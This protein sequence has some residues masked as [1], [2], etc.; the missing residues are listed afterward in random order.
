MFFKQTKKQQERDLKYYVLEGVFWAITHYIGIVFLVPYLIRFNASTMEI[1]LINT[2]PLFLSSFSVLFSY[3][4]LK[5]FESQKHFIVFFLTLQA[6]FWIPLAFVGYFFKDHFAVWIIIILYCITIFAEQFTMG[7]YR[8]WIGK[9]FDVSKIVQLNAKKQIILN[10]VSIVPLF[11]AGFILDALQ[12]NSIFGFTLIFIIAGVFK[13]GTVMMLKKMSQTE[14][15]E[16]IIKES[17]KKAKSPFVIFKEVVVKNKQFVYFLLI[18]TL[19]YFGMYVASPFYRYYFLEILHFNYKQYVLLEIAT[20]LSLILSYYYWGKICDKYGSTKVL[21]SIILFLPLY[22]FLIIAFGANFWLLFLLNFYDGVLMAGLTLGIYGYFYQ[23]IKSDLVHHMS[24]FL[25]FQSS[26]M[27]LGTL[28]GGFISSNKFFW[29]NGVEKNGLFLIF[30]ISII[31]RIVTLFFIKKIKDTNKKQIN[32]PRSI[33]LQKPIMFGF[34]QFLNFTKQR[35]K[36]LQKNVEIEQ[37]KLRNELI[38]QKNTIEKSI[39]YLV[40]KEKQIFEKLMRLDKKK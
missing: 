1:G 38:K 9:I 8:E 7:V 22:P 25:I 17:K 26:A 31:F 33:I 10:L 19:I 28:L 2:L 21:K 23:N 39:E 15:K 14:N 6:L 4:V 40:K 11:L 12:K 29:F 18:V 16:E 5:H 3:N 13:F 34:S 36:T 27:L 35:S 37:K 24:F 20:I 30:I 32:L